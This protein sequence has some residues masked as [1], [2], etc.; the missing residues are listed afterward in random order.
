MYAIE[1]SSHN[2]DRWAI[3][4]RVYG[5]HLSEHCYNIGRIYPSSANF[6]GMIL[7]VDV[8]GNV[9]VQHNL[10]VDM[11]TV[12][13]G[14]DPLLFQADSAELKLDKPNSPM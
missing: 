10:S 9:M 5:L 7:K 12:R 4:A 8:T 2:T 6:Q 1:P 11:N 14:C 13:R 3:A